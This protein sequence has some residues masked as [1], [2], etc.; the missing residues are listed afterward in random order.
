MRNAYTL[1]ISIVLITIFSYLS[2]SILETK[3]LRSTNLTNQYLYIQGKNHLQFFKEYIKSIDL[4]DIEKLEIKDDIFLIYAK[5][6][7][8]NSI[9]TIDIFVKA[10]DY[11]ISLYEKVTKE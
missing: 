9:F 4:K 10:K 11:D 7:N 1:L 6:E 3:T 5:I 2:I 8:I